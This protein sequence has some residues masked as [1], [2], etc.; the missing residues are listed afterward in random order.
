MFKT[1]VLEIVNATKPGE[2]ISYGDVAVL[3]GRPRAARAV[4]AVLKANDA[5]CPW[6]RVV[7][8]KHEVSIKDPDLRR[9]QI[10]RLRAEGHVI[11]TFGVIQKK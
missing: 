5:D 1:R 4:S 9:E 11:D 2:L 10:E 8:K 6:H 7:N 3:A